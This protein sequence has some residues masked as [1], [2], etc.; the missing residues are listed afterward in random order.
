[1][2]NLCMI[3]QGV[4]VGGVL[5][6]G[7]PTT[8]TLGVADYTKVVGFVL[9]SAFTGPVFT[10]VGY[11]GGAK[12]GDALLVYPLGLTLAVLWFYVRLSILNLAPET[13][14]SVKLLAWLHIS[15]IT[16]ITLIIAFIFALPLVI[17]AA[18][19]MFG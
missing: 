7:F 1:M 11:L 5:S 18:K 10:Y 17:Q 14:N 6:L 4:F 15:A 9:V 13:S 3:L 19:Q 2:A 16:I 8:T 12:L